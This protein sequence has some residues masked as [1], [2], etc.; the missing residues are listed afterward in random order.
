MKQR[1]HDIRYVQG[2]TTGPTHRALHDLAYETGR[3]VGDL[4][5]DGVLLVLQ[6]HGRAHGLPEPTPPNAD[7][8]RRE[9][10]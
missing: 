9:Q 1:I 5:G 3:S 2:T 7:S 6:L 8:G 10:V 4:V